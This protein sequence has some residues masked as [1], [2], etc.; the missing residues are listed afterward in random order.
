MGKATLSVRTGSI[1]S[2][3]V[4]FDAGALLPPGSA[5]APAFAF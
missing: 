1:T 4:V 3:R 5:K 2:Q